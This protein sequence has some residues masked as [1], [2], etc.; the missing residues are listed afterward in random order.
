MNCPSSGI[1]KTEVL[2]NERYIL[3]RDQFSKSY[4]E[5][6]QQEGARQLKILFD[7]NQDPSI[8]DSPYRE[9]YFLPLTVIENQITA[10][11]STFKINLLYG[12]IGNYR[13]QDLYHVKDDVL[14]SIKKQD[15]KTYLNL[16]LNQPELKLNELT[17]LLD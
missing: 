17:V 5:L 8:A 9:E 2:E 10:Q 14:V 11:K 13:G 6:Q 12:R 3:K 16:T 7:Q 15:G 1:C 4:V